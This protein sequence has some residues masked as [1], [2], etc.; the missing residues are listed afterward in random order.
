MHGEVQQRRKRLMSGKEGAGGD[1]ASGA[2]IGEERPGRWKQIHRMCTGT[3]NDLNLQCSAAAFT[4]QFNCCKVID[5]HSTQS[6]EW[7]NFLLPQPVP[8]KRPPPKIHLPSRA[9][10][11]VIPTT[12]SSSSAAAKVAGVANTTPRLCAAIIRLTETNPHC[13]PPPHLQS[14]SSSSSPPPPPNPGVLLA[15]RRDSDT[16]CTRSPGRP[17]T[18]QDPNHVHTPPLTCS[19]VTVV[20]S[21]WVC[22]LVS[23]IS[24]AK[25]QLT[26]KHLGPGSLLTP[27]RTKLFSLQV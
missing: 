12:S 17:S 27:R 14:H 10:T 20:H 23:S 1:D 13:I 18:V 9:H 5:H 15:L 6:D 3:S 16:Q 25:Q 2:D 22:S 21:G 11:D 4:S 24:M 26:M 8:D 7:G 19:G